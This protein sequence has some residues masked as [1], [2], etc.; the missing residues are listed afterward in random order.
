M[1]AP[2]ETLTTIINKLRALSDYARIGAD[3]L[4]SRADTKADMAPLMRRIEAATRA[5]CE[6]DA[7]GSPCLYPTCNCPTR[8]KSVYIKQARAVVAALDNA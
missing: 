6:I 1:T 7:V 2:A 8:T 5:L 4:E 3:E